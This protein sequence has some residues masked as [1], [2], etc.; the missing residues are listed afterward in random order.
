MFGFYCTVIII[1]NQQAIF[2]DC[3]VQNNLK[4]LFRRYSV[5]RRQKKTREAIF[6]A[7]ITLLSEKKYSQISVQEIIDAA[8]VGRTTFYAHFETK[9]YLLKELCEELFEHIIN[10]AVEHTGTHGHYSYESAPKSVFLHL[11]QHLQKND[12]HI[13][14]LLS[15]ENNGIFGRYFKMNLK[16]LIKTQCIDE[17]A[18]RSLALP[19]DFLINHIAAVFVE[20]IDWWL[21]RNMKEEPEVITDYFLKVIRPVLVH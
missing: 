1:N 2:N 13:L 16:I 10:S 20:T 19:E 7:F 4:N 11:I 18:V 21:T 3:S 15:S 6:E 17:D 14:D 12:N 5:D 9:D 8:D